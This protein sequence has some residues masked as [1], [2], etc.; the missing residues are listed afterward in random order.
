MGT[1]FNP[2][3]TNSAFHC[4][5]EY[6]NIS[7]DVAE[8]EEYM[9]WE[10][11]T[12]FEKIGVNTTLLIFHS[13]QMEWDRWSISGPCDIQIELAGSKWIKA[14][15]TAGSPKEATL[16]LPTGEKWRITPKEPHEFDSSI[17][18]RGMYSEHWYVREQL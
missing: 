4:R 13:P 1:N 8:N 3:R 9:G 17:Y 16:E 2:I 11:R 5:S 7:E 15:I 18:L 10:A 6:V 14:K 12:N